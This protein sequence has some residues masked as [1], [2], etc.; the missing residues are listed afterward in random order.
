MHT[1]FREMLC[2]ALYK[3]HL[4]S[5]DGVIRIGWCEGEQT[6]IYLIECERCA[7]L[8]IID[9]MYLDRILSQDDGKSKKRKLPPPTDEP[10]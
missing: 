9:Q 6:W 3:G 10:A 8:A 2:E 4:L 5:R 1:P 7:R